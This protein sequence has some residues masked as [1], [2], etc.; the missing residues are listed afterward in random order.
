MKKFN[1]LYQIILQ[2]LQNQKIITNKN[3]IFIPL[4]TKSITQQFGY[5]LTTY[6]DM[7]D[8]VILIVSNIT[9]Q[10]KQK[11]QLS[12]SNLEKII[13]ILNYFKNEQQK[14]VQKIISQI[15][16]NENIT[17]SELNSKI[18]NIISK[19]VNENFKN[20][21]KKTILN[22]K[23]N[24]FKN[25]QNKDI[26]KDNQLQL[27]QYIKKYKLDNVIVKLSTKQSPVDDII[28]FINTKCKKCTITINMKNSKSLQKYFVKQNQNIFKQDLK[29]S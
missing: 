5:T 8:N 20:Q 4:A 23:Q 22:I 6:S 11:Q 3:L 13:K 17:F 14:S 7:Y 9:K 18:S 12:L 28:Q 2:N 25:V 21:L 24:I 15:Q 16:N 19:T 10:K 26:I 27:D 1:K 29:F